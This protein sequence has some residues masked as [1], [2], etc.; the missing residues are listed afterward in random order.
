[1]LIA[2]SVENF[3]SIR[4]LQTLSLA[5]PRTDH[6]L[7]WSNVIENGN[8]RLLKTAALFGPNASGKSNVI[9]ALIWLRQFVLNS[10]KEGQAGEPISAQPFRLSTATEA[11]PCHFEIEFVQDTY[12][13]R[14]G[15][16]VTSARV[17]SEWLFRKAPTAKPAKLF[18]RE[19]QR[20]DISGEFFRE[21]RGL[22]DRTRENALF[23]SVCAQFAGPQS[24]KI[25]EWMGRM[26]PV[27]GLSERNFFN[28]TAKRLR[29]P[30]HRA[31][32]LELAQKADLNICA[33]RSEVEELTELKLPAE[34]PTHLR[35][36]LLAQKLV[37]ADIKTTH[38]KRDAEGKVVG[39][40][41]FDLEEDE[42]QG[43]QK[44]IALSGPI[45]HILEEGL[46]LIVDELEARL[47]PKLTQAIVDLF[48]SPVNRKNAQLIFAAHDV[49]L[50]EPERFR[51][52]QVWFTEKDAQGATDLY[53]LAEFD[54]QEVRADTKF[55]RQYLLGLFGAV[56]QLAHFQ[57]AAAHA[58]SQ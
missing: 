26:R 42:S 57:E 24:E 54:P 30:E 4:D 52:D 43:T 49:T 44:F 20:F 6:H 36:R 51:R 53:S 46:I 15:F 25:I 33:L 14:Y 5:E 47:H 10:S 41:E 28:F 55:S 38:E 21:G 40:V 39:R 1:M 9:K 32:L 45:T 23:L 12:E 50:L 58:T 19:R 48:H 35:D 18:T 7:E 11:A 17:E 16:E 31:R 37:E 8:R 34:M 56:P 13:F 27:S 22:E 3:R 29:N 2:F